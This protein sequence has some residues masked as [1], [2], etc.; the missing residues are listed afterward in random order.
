MGWGR[1]QALTLAQQFNLLKSNPIC[2]GSGR[3]TARGLTWTYRVRPTVLSREYTVRIE[4]ERDGIPAVFVRSPDLMALAGGRKI[5]HVYRDPLRLCLYLPKA[6]EWTD[7]LRIDQTM[8]PW[9]TVWLY[10]FE[11]W[12]VSDDWKGGGQHPSPSDNARLSRRLRRR[13]G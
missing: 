1:R 9:A 12:L 6:K 5:P 10:Y 4:L 3:L 8:V 7:I 2:A 11:E 13:L